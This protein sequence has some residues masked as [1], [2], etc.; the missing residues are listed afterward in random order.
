MPDRFGIVKELF[1][2]LF[3]IA[4]QANRVSS[5][6]THCKLVDDIFRIRPA[7]DVIT[8]KHFNRMW[9]RP[10]MNVLVDA[11]QCLGKQ[12]GAAVNIADRIDSRLRRRKGL[13]R[14]RLAAL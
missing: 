10:S 5:H 1:Q 2:K 14:L 6:H 8:E 4:A 3:V 13:S 7:V 9:N 12:I 11:I